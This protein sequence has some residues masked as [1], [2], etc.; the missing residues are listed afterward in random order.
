[1]RKHL[2]LLLAALATAFALGSCDDPLSDDNGGGNGN[3]NG[4]DDGKVTLTVSPDSLTFSAQGG[5][6]TIQV[7]TN[8]KDWE[9]H[10]GFTTD[11]MDWSIEKR[12]ANLVIKGKTIE[13][14]L[15]ENKDTL[16]RSGIIGIFLE[17]IEKE[18]HFYQE[19]KPNEGQGERQIPDYHLDPNDP[20]QYGEAGKGNGYE[21][22][23]DPMAR[24]ITPDNPLFSFVD[25]E[26]EYYGVKYYY[27][28]PKIREQ[29]FC[30]YNGDIFLVQPCE[31]FPEGTVV[32]A[33]VLDDV[34]G[35]PL[36]TFAPVPLETAFESL[37]FDVS[38]EEGFQPEV[39]A[40]IDEDGNEIPLQAN[41]TRGIT[42]QSISFTLPNMSWDLNDNFS[43]S[44]SLSMEIGLR[45]QAVVSD[46]ELVYGNLVTDLEYA[47]SG[48]MSGK[49]EYNYEWERKFTLRFAPMMI[50]PLMVTPTAPISF[51]VRCAVSGQVDVTVSVHDAVSFGVMYQQG[52][53]TPV[54]RKI[55]GNMEP[56]NAL[57]IG[58][59]IGG[60][61]DLGIKPGVGVDFYGGLLSLSVAPKI[62]LRTQCGIFQDD[63]IATVTQL[64]LNNPT[65]DI[66]S[67]A[68]VKTSI[69]LGMDGYVKVPGWTKQARLPNEVSWPL[70]EWRF[71]PT[72][73][74]FSYK[75]GVKNGNLLT[76]SGHL[77]NKLLLPSWLGRV[78]LEGYKHPDND[79]SVSEQFMIPLDYA[80]LSTL[81]DKD[82][83]AFTGTMKMEE[84][85]RY[86]LSRF[87]VDFCGV[88]IATG[89]SEPAKMRERRDKAVGSIFPE[90][91]HAYDIRMEQAMRPVLN[92]LLAVRKDE[93]RDCNWEDPD[94]TFGDYSNVILGKNEEGVPTCL[95]N[96]DYW[97]MA[98]DFSISPINEGMD[99]RWTIRG[100]YNDLGNV[101][102]DEPHYYSINQ[103]E[104][105][106]QG[107]VTVHSPYVTDS[108]RLRDKRKFDFSRCAISSV[109]TLDAM[110]TSLTLDD[111]P[112]LES[113][114]IG[115]SETQGKVITM[116]KLSAKGSPA[117]QMTL[118]DCDVNDLSSKLNDVKVNKL[119]LSGQCRA[120]TLTL[121]AD[122]TK[123][124][125]GSGPHDITNLYLENLP[126]L[127]GR[128]DLTYGLKAP[129]KELRM[130][131]C[132]LITELYE[133]DAEK[134]TV[135]DCP[136]V[137]GI[138]LSTEQKA[139]KTGIG[140]VDANIDHHYGALKE[141]S[142][143]G[144]Y[145]NLSQLSIYSATLGGLVPDYFQTIRKRGYAVY[146]QKYA[147]YDA[148][149]Y[150]GTEH[151]AVYTFDNGYYY[152]PEPDNGRHANY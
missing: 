122:I 117:V 35:F 133:R 45:A 103:W 78:Y 145:S 12:W 118:Y 33:T 64:D 131:N 80:D 132:P 148:T 88:P 24:I 5:T 125:F 69:V 101:T 22:T 137:F 10:T 61:I 17:G 140:P 141:F 26:W 23:L 11:I 93:W 63:F 19:G 96:V 49:L 30:P 139:E 84:D 95:I 25:H 41:M 128:I 74:D 85:T 82:S 52:E 1:M 39:L 108:Y 40:L 106:N 136:S 138:Y 100:G 20:H 144:D 7:T 92:A 31:R 6:Q 147:Y 47:L 32:Q 75:A 15:E 91:Y 8:A 135:A 152:S 134:V 42:K 72:V 121:P 54:Y 89:N 94:Y 70:Q 77:K 13:L 53:V 87:C 44:P 76:V 110:A 71:V 150:G 68:A 62:A 57:K 67:N 18:I 107:N 50:G 58:G 151:Y 66:S 104:I 16:S 21:F 9:E 123:L 119:I 113:I 126:K 79:P 97:P 116:P 105:G 111:C 51:F 43:L 36:I 83:T 98:G 81:G 124:S 129:L 56:T 65:P 73:G 59:S 102:I 120:T 112:K 60:Q 143:S 46:H 38:A 37:N 48:T 90:W 99:F 34:D 127:E 109:T 146:P 2:L 115:S 142:L 29:N 28:D 14:T 27:F 149:D 55:Q 4:K 3:G 86:M 130:V 114:G